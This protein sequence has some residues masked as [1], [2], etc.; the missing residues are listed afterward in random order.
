MGRSP[1]GYGYGEVMS[2]LPFIIVG[3][4]FLI[5]VL[6][7]VKSKKRGGILVL[8]DFI[9]NDADFEFL[10]IIGRPSGFT[11]WLKSLFGKDSITSFVCNKQEVKLE[12]SGIKYNIP[13]RHVTCVATGINK[14]ILL[15]I[16]GIIYIIAGIACASI[17]SSIVLVGLILGAVFIVLYALNK[18]MQF[19]IFTVENNPIISIQV[20]GQNIDFGKFTSASNALNKTILEVK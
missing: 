12:S 8:K 16:L 7:S 4:I 1:F 14:P 20:K 5:V 10:K 13:L 11:S 3:V 18:N 19:S 6:S 2:F 9:F 17:H 15:L